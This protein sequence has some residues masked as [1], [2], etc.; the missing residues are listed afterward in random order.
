[1]MPSEKLLKIDS[2][3]DVDFAGM[4][5]HE[6]VDDPVC[7]KSR[8]GYEIMVANDPITWWSK[9]QSETVYLLWKLK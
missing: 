5:G 2:F 6:A 9:L 4:Y 3:P 7:L 8:T 1:M